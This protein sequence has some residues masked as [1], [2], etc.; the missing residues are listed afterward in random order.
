[1]L[2][3]TKAIVLRNKAY[4]DTSGIVTLYTE[5]LGLQT[6]IVNG[7]RKATKTSAG[8]A[9][10]LQ[11]AN[12]LQIEAYYNEQRNLQRLKEFHFHYLYQNI[13]RDATKNLVALF[14]ME[15]LYVCIKQP[16]KNTDLYGFA[17]DVLME[18]DKATPTEVANLPLYIMVHL[19]NFL[20][21]QIQDNYTAHC[22]YLDLK[23]GYYVEELPN[24]PQFL[25][26]TLSE[27]VA[28]VLKVMHPNELKELAFNKDIRNQII[29]ALLDFYKLHLP[30]FNGL[31][32]LVVLRAVLH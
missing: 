27:L 11:P 23:E 15:L 1:M 18:L 31:K 29:N 25:Q 13:L 2:Q 7:I 9:M 26:G 4:G 5:A 16:E 20:G 30:S 32:S 14:F 28:Q 3:V 6:Y 22:T 12:I 19:S 24:H 10:Y 8:K 21:F 17:E